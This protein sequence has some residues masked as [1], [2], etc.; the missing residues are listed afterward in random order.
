VQVA[1]VKPPRGPHAANDGV[2]NAP[3]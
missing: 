2:H 3:I 1:Q